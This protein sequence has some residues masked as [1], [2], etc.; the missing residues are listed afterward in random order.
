MKVRT[1]ARGSELSAKVEEVSK[2][3]KEISDE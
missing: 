2:G 1:G 3:G